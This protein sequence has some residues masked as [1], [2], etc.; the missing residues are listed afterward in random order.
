MLK[1]RNE[2]LEP[3]V[4]EY[5]AIHDIIHGVLECDPEYA[6]TAAF[7]EQYG[8]KPVQCANT[9][10]VVSKNEHPEF[11]ACVILASTKL[12][13]NKRVCELMGVKH[14]SFARTDQIQ[15]LSGMRIG[16]ITAF[17]LPDNLPIYIDAEVLS[18]PEVIMGGGNRISKLKL[19]PREL[20]KLSN[21][22][23]GENIA[24]IK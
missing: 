1:N 20:Q 5:L 9:I 16:G 14:A 11:A 2:L 10:I 22:F 17:G 15:E 7:C 8:F 23:I 12:D 3:K 19:D 13:V 4:R 24:Q 18:Q 21:V 6:D